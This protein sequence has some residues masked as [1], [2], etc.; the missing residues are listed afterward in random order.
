MRPIC[1]ECNREMV[2]IAITIPADG[3]FY[4]TWQCDCEYRDEEYAP[5][6]IIADIMRAREWH[7]GSVAREIAWP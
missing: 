4:K 1:P 6:G 7:D 2:F 3:C 5:D